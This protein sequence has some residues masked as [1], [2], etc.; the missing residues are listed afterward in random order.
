[1][2]RIQLDITLSGGRPIPSEKMAESVGSGWW[3]STNRQRMA[4]LSVV[5]FS[6][7]GLHCAC[8]GAWHPCNSGMGLVI[9]Y[10][11]VL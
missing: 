11:G 8:G 7:R 3:P 1:M 10:M 2:D 9:Q 4:G 6:G 5:L